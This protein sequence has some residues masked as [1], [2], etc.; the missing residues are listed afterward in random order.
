MACFEIPE[1]F[2]EGRFPELLTISS[3]RS[4]RDGSQEQKA[5]GDLKIQSRIEGKKC[6]EV[7][8]CTEDMVVGVGRKEENK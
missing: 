1:T 4:C 8:Y 2:E 7:V 5:H 3:R 6:A